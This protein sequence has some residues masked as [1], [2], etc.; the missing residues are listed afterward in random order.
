M[1]E[2]VLKNPADVRRLAE[3]LRTIAA[4]SRFDTEGEE[5]A[6]TLAQALSDLEGAFRTLVD[7]LLPRVARTDNVTELEDI[8]HAVGEEFRHVLYHLRDCQFYGY[9]REKPPRSADSESA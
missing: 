4:V 3:K 7:D 2:R 8:L 6:W 9:L 5:Q 1:P